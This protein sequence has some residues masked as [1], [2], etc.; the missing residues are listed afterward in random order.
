MPEE[1]QPH[2]SFY[3]KMACFVNG[4]DPNP[5]SVNLRNS[6]PPLSNPMM[7]N[8]GLGKVVPLRLANTVVARPDVSADDLTSQQTIIPRPQREQQEEE[9]AKF[10]EEEEPAPGA[11]KLASPEKG[12]GR[13]E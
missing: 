1:Y 6:A 9:E 10:E 13:Q 8:Y 12:S 3:G 11:V 7:E 2:R 4:I 5:P